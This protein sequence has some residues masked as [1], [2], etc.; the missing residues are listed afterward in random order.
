M[1]TKRWKAK[2]SSRVALSYHG[3]FDDVEIQS[4]LVALYGRLKNGGKEDFGSSD[5]WSA[6]YGA[7]LE[8]SGISFGASVGTDHLGDQDHQFMTAGIGYTF[9]EVSTSITYG[10]VWASN[11]DFSK[12]N[13]VDKPGNLVFSAGYDLAPGLALQGD[14][15][16]FDND[17]NASYDGSTGDTGW[18]GVARFEVDV[19]I[20]RRQA[21]RDGLD[22]ARRRW[23]VKV[24]PEPLASGN[25]DRMSKQN[26]AD[27]PDRLNSCQAG[28]H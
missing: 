24:P 10:W 3:E 20:L 15:A 13:G 16:L 2:I 6:T 26:R 28:L 22:A 19:L 18:A 1:A 9:G 14:V 5:W 25:G 8:I 7:T 11:D 4:S 27:A 12:A 17:T 21:D 23:R